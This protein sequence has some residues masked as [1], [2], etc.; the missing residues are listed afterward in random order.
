[1]PFARLRRSVLFT[2]GSHGRALEKAGTLDVDVVVIDLEDSVGP[3]DKTLA[4]DQAR[5]ILQ[6]GALA[7]REVVVRLNALETEE[8]ARDLDAIAP[9]GPD[10][11]LLPKVEDAD[12]VANLCGAL[13]AGDA[14]RGLAL[15][16]M[17][18][19]PKGVVNIN[20]I[21][22]LG[23]KRRL[24]ALVLGINDLG[25]A[26]RMPAGSRRSVLAP[27]MLD[28]V[29]AARAH[30]LMAI[31]SVFNAHDDVEGFG[32][33]AREARRFGFDGKSLIHP[34]QIEPC[35]AAFAPTADETDW[36]HKVVA[37]FQDPHNVERG[38][39]TVDGRMVERLHLVEA[40]HILRL[41][42]EV[43]APAAQ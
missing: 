38:V 17:I 41:A 21:A 13:D 8:G 26:M 15:W 29:L 42:G 16:A 24:A 25:A 23:A 34:S 36:A 12:D 11:L 32:L 2:P 4:R 19:T 40:E 35:H 43:A 10:A 22:A 37:A 30:G 33:E 5:T 6:S 7:G 28:V 39:I 31:D 1:M 18:E 9:L 3:A 27:V 14:P 20:A